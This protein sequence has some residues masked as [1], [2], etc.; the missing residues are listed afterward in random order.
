M[1]DIIQIV[2]LQASSTP[3]N[4]KKQPGTQ[5]LTRQK[6]GAAFGL[7]PQMISFLKHGRKDAM[8]IPASNRG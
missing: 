1:L 6:N 2:N 7:T 8:N 5:S 3:V 4:N